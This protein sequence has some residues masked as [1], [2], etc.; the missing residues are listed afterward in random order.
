MRDA[1][2]GS[3]WSQRARGGKDSIENGQPEEFIDGSLKSGIACFADSPTS[4]EWMWI[5]L[6]DVA[7]QQLPS[8]V[9]KRAVNAQPMFA[10]A[11]DLDVQRLRVDVDPRRRDVNGAKNWT[12]PENSDCANL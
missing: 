11:P 12:R 4:F 1:K 9:R 8:S 7:D 2:T 3:S 10:P 5:S 6:D